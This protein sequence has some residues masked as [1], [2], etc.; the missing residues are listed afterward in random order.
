MIIVLNK[1]KENIMSTQVVK[2]T[3]SVPADLVKLADLVAK[4]KK[5][6]RSKVVSSCLQE[7]ANQREQSEMEEGYRAMASDEQREKD[8][9]EW[10]EA[11]IENF[12]NAK[13]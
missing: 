2:V 8:A 1:V 11:S 6:S 4:E 7:M 10:A 5:I 12:E 13:R 9:L 3:V